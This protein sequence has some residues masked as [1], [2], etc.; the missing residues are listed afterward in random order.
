MA[1]QLQSI[2]ISEGIRETRAIVGCSMETTYYIG[3][4]LD[5]ECRQDDSYFTYWKEVFSQSIVATSFIK[6][7]ISHNCQQFSTIFSS[8]ITIAIEYFCLPLWILKVLQ[9]HLENVITIVQSTYQLHVQDDYQWQCSVCTQVCIFQYLLSTH[10][11]CYLYMG[12]IYIYI[13]W[14]YQYSSCI[15]S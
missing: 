1:V 7:Q 12:Q 9:L 13:L 3:R 11:F 4:V 6:Q 14:C 15:Y 8:K 5:I 10:V 2:T